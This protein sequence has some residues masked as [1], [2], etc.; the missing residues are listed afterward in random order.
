[1]F[2][3]KVVRENLLCSILPP[4]PDDVDDTPPGLDPTLPTKERYEQHRND[5][6]CSG[7]HVLMDPIGFG[8]EHYD[9]IGAWREMDGQV[10]VDAVGELAATDVDGEFDGAIELAD[11]LVQS[12]A[13]QACVVRQWMRFGLGRIETEADACTERG[14]T[15]TFAESGGDVH[16]LV[17][18]VATSRAMRYLRIAGGGE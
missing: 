6:N 3:G 8:L 16:E 10:P 2:R 4:P 1:V 9:A 18:A 13:V 15:T 11:K 12:Q 14:L 17:V 5:P 7:C